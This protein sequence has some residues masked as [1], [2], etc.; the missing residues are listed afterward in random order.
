MSPSDFTLSQE[1]PDRSRQATGKAYKGVNSSYSF[2]ACTSHHG[3]TSVQVIHL[4]TVGVSSTDRGARSSGRMRSVET[5]ASKGVQGKSKSEEK[6]KVYNAIEADA[7]EADVAFH[8]GWDEQSNAESD[9]GQSDVKY[10]LD[11]IVGIKIDGEDVEYLVHWTGGGEAGRSWEP[12]S[13]I[14]VD[15]PQAVKDF[16]RRLDKERKKGFARQM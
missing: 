2:I 4:A 14:L 10:E 12:A 8:K 7:N 5:A 15:A 9:D 13:A 11:K 3:P 6:H 16:E 1:T